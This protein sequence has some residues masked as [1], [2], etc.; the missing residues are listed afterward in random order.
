MVG[1]IIDRP[2]TA[3]ELAIRLEDESWCAS[4]AYRIRWPKGFVC[5]TCGASNPES[6]FQDKPLCRACGRYSS[7][8]AGTLLHGS[9]KSLST[10]LRALWWICGES[11]SISIMKLRKYLGFSSYQTGWAWMKKLRYAIELANQEKC[12][13]ITLVDSA[14]AGDPA[15]SAQLLVAVESIARGRTTGRLRMKLC[16]SL[17][18]EVI[19]QFCGDVLATGSIIVFPGRKPFSSIHLQE[20]LYTVD[21]SSLFHEDIENICT[22]YRRWRHRKKYSWSHLC[23]RQ[24]LVEEFCFFHNGVLTAGKMDI[25][26]T[27]VR[28]ALTHPPIDFNTLKE[29]L[30]HPGGAR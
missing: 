29:V 6:E 25:F 2:R 23:C 1:S 27:L 16:R 5:P 21:D 19:S 26:E 28:V 15:E 11:S 8:T 24:D 30:V 4:Y 18:Q 17:D 20:M 13:G 12:R 7:I 9:K 14:P 22:S 10:W 3:G